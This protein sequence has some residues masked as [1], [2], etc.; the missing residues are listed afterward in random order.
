VSAKPKSGRIRRAQHLEGLRRVIAQYGKTSSGTDADRARLSDLHY[1]LQRELWR[2]VTAS[3]PPDGAF[4]NV[5]SASRRNGVA[6]RTGSS[7]IC[8]CGC[9]SAIDDVVTWQ[10]AS[11]GPRGNRPDP[12]Q[13]LAERPGPIDE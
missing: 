7:F 8:A 5:F 9:G 13:A 4:V 10:Y 11:A 12:P 1:L 6:K 3:D 2:P